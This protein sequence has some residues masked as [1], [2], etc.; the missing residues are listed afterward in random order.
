MS[1]QLDGKTAIITGAASGIGR[2]CARLFAARGARVV[3]ADVDAT[4]AG[5]VVEELGESGHAI[6]TDVTD[7]GAVE[8]MVRTA[9]EHF[10]SVDILVNSAGP[11]DGR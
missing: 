3:A 8:A 5:Q 11:G 6:T 1:R 4:G 9:A 10:G 2:A 7:R